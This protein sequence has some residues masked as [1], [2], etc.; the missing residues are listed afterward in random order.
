[1][2]VGGFARDK[3]NERFSVFTRSL[4]FLDLMIYVI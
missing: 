1:M 2:L 4:C 3:L